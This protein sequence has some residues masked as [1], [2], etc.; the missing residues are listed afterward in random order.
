MHNYLRQIHG[1]K[2][3]QLD[4]ELSKNA[5]NWAR[6]IAATDSLRHSKA[7]D[8]GENIAYSCSGNKIVAAVNDSVNDW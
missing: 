8:Y 1:S 4:K 3:L 6:Y 7:N 2:P 5:K